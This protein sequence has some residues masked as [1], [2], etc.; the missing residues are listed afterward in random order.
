MY[1][2]AD[3]I[4]V[5]NL[6]KDDGSTARFLQV[7]LDSQIV[8]NHSTFT[9]MT[10]SIINCFSSTMELDNISGENIISNEYIIDW[11]FCTGLIFS[12]LTL[13]NWESQNLPGII[14]IRGS[15]VEN[16]E[17]WEFTDVQLVAIIFDNSELKKSS[18]NTFNGMNKGILLQSG[19]IWVIS[20]SV[21]V[22]M[23]QNI[24]DG[25]IYQSNIATDGS[26]IGKQILI[27]TFRNHWFTCYYWKL[28]FYKQYSKE[29][30]SH[31]DRL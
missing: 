21:F 22:N 18:G 26:A 5:S 29:W 19:S 13:N 8:M 17:Y 6:S 23:V 20:D 1:I 25:L 11:Y 24:K 2:D 15:K 28:Y 3:N 31:K 14:N 4:T 9:N 10:V 27:I 30:R 7:E 16:I 12:H